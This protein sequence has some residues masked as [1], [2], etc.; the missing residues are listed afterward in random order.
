VTLPALRAEA[1]A[2]PAD[3]DAWVWALW[4]TGVLLWLAA[5]M[6]AA[7]IFHLPRAALL[8]IQQQR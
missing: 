1:L 2:A 3:F 7:G 5:A 6:A 8:A 4:W